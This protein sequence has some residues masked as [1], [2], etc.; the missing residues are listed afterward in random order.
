MVQALRTHRVNTLAELRRIERILAASATADVSEVMTKACESQCS[1]KVDLLLLFA[2][3]LFR[4]ILCQL[5]YA[6]DR[7]SKL[8]QELSVQVS[9]LS[10]I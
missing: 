5:Q 7:A 10:G 3:Q 4:G 2:D 1:A 8:D 6:F 9:V